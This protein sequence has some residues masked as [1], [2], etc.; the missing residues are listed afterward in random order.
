MTTVN[1]TRLALALDP[2][3]FPCIAPN[4][5]PELSWQIETNDNTAV[6]LAYEI[7][8]DGE[9]TATTGRV[10]GPAS[11]NV[12]WPFPPLASR[13]RA[14]VRVRVWGTNGEPSGWSEPLVVEGGLYGATDWTAQLVGPTDDLDPT[15]PGPAFMLRRDFH[16][17]AKPV[18]ARLHITSH[19]IF[20]AEINGAPVGDDVLAPGWTSY[21]HRL[22]YRTFDVTSLVGAGANAIGVAVADG[23]FRGPLGF[24]GGAT[25]IYGNRLGVFAQLEIETDDG[26][27]CVVATDNEWRSARGPIVSTGLYDG[28]C[29]DARLEQP[30][31]STAH[32]D[33][34]QWRPVEVRSFDVAVLEAPLGPPVRRHEHLR[35]VHSSRPDDRRWRYDFGQNASGRLRITASGN[36]GAAFTVRHAEVLEHEELGLRPLRA[37]AARD[38]YIFAAGGSIVWEPTFTI[39]GFRYAEID[40]DPGVEI[41][42]VEMVVIHSDL[43][44]TGWFECSEP[45]I[46]KLHDNV[47]WSMRS[48]FVDVPTDCPQRD[49]R[50]GWTGDIQVFAPT[51]TFLYDCAGFLQSW[52]RDLAH[53]QNDTGTVPFYVPWIELVFPPVPTTAWGD[54]AVIVPE[55]L[56]RRYG[57]T[58]VLNAQYASMCAWVREIVGCLGPSGLW[59][60][61][62]QFGDWLDPAAPPDR[63]AD[64]RT[65]PALVATA[66]LVRSASALARFAD[67][68]DRRDDADEFRA[69]ADSTRAAFRREFVTPG[70]RLAC[71]AQTAYAIAIAFDLLDE[72]ERPAAGRRLAALVAK[73]DFRI[74]TGF[75][76]TP[77]VCDALERVGAID[78]AYQLLN[79]RAC[80]SWLYPVTMGA[81]TVWERWDSMLPDG[82]INPGEMTSFNH[83]ALGAVADWLHR[84]VAGLDYAEPGGRHLRFAPHPG[85]GLTHAEARHDTPYGHAS[86]RWERT[87][88]TLNV[89]VHVPPNCCA[90]VDID[91][92]PPTRDRQRP[93]L[94]R[95]PVSPR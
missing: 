67:L 48:N 59:D 80:P 1:V 41:I 17:D 94:L 54:A 25:D 55:A 5:Q 56:Y 2:R 68:L 72:A 65:D 66:Y 37:A 46:N 49:E 73:D 93:S 30:G 9:S 28:E 21:Q 69:V 42:D 92:L 34:S 61:G 53:E 79:Q 26:T 85:G 71:D 27:T 8:L 47:L 4:P 58:D 7:K 39:H 11:I 76:G 63:P 86:I 75:V 81:T 77:L 74:G 78:V 50:L 89:V 60:T 84:S 24:E 88:S 6:Q 33:A 87:G 18:R 19:G 64:A 36:P 45:L 10:L 82:S 83:Y 12:G 95:N 91:G 57:S 44:R 20:D 38:S 31:W 62:F 43:R 15:R 23:W 32:F 14:T 3:T 90:D 35:S 13:Q 29:Y 51:A 40:C 70:G 22:R 16:V 52:L